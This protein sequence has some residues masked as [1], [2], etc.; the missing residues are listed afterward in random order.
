MTEYV[1]PS[2]KGGGR[3]DTRPI[4]FAVKQ[5][6]LVKSMTYILYSIIFILYVLSSDISMTYQLGHASYLGQHSTSIK[7]VISVKY[8]RLTNQNFPNK[9]GI[10]PILWVQQ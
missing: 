7:H 1:T 5:Y 9:E 6:T 10:L 3:G 4:I 2:R 8:N